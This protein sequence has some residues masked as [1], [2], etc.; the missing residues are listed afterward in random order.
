MQKGSTDSRQGTLEF[1]CIGRISPERNGGV[2][3]P[4]SYVEGRFSGRKGKKM[5]KCRILTPHG[6]TC[7]RL[8]GHEGTRARRNH[9]AVR[10]NREPAGWE[11]RVPMDTQTTVLLAHAQTMVREGLRG[12]LERTGGIRVVGEAGSGEKAVRLAREKGP[13]IVLVDAAIRETSVIRVIHALA[14]QRPTTRVVV[15]TT[16]R[17]EES[18]ERIIEAG[19]MESIGTHRTGERLAMVVEMVAA[20]RTC[21]PPRASRLVQRR[22]PNNGT[23]LEERLAKLNEKER[24]VLELTARG[25]TAREIGIRIHLATKSVDNYRSAI[26]KKLGITTRAEFVSVALETGLLDTGLS[27][28]SSG[29]HC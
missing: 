3:E 16:P 6:G 25:F 22:A 17:D 15:L 20:G 12:I 28:S 27:P 13:A 7:L 8:K 2:F 9:R 29:Y 21:F 14:M 5:A 26:R 11:G 18:L 10:T 23:G 1:G 24:G 4:D 19:A